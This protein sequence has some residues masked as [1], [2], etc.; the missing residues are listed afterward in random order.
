MDLMPILVGGVV[1]LAVFTGIV[2][3]GHLV[4]APVRIHHE[5]RKELS[6]QAEQFKSYLRHSSAVAQK[7]GSNITHLPS[8]AA[9]SRQIGTELR[10]IRHKIEVVRSTRPR[11][12]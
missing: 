3:C 5:V 12:H 11:P 4:L 6:D 2:V 8:L 1:G 9:A 7:Y 10:D